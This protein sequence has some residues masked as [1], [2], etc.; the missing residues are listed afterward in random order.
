MT[1]RPINLDRQNAIACGLD[2][3]SGLP[4]ANCGHTLRYVK[5]GGCVHCARTIANEQ[6]EARKLLLQ[7]RTPL[8]SAPEVEVETEEDAE[9]RRQA[10]ID[11]LM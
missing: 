3:Y 6:R 11:T 1:G 7:S 10:D 9:A 5:G 8:D 4:H 2:K